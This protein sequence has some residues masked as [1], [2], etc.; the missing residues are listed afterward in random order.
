[1]EQSGLRERYSDFK[2][3]WVT[4][5]FYERFEQFIALLMT[6]LVA[7]IIVVAAWELTKEVLMLVGQRVLDPLDYRTFQAIFGE[8]MI[9]LIALEFK[10]SIIRVVAHRRGIIQVQTVL[11]IALLAI[12]RKFIILDAE[13]SPAHIMALASVVVALGVTYWL[14]R[15]RDIGQRALPGH[16]S[17]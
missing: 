8:I 1:M 10:H 4:L 7:L 2:E 16:I 5:S 14:I 13:M 17:S 9:V 11:L 15:D 3:N 12:S 6:W